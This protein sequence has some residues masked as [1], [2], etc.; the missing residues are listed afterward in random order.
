[1]DYS[2]GLNF[3]PFWNFN[4]TKRIKWNTMIL[5]KSIFSFEQPGQWKIELFK[6]CLNN[7]FAETGID[8]LWM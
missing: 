8:E 7:S 2:V 5:A 3:K 4:K 1:M 6:M